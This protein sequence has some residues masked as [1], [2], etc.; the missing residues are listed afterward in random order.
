LQDFNLIESAYGGLI[1]NFLIGIFFSS[2]IAFFSL[3][4]KLHIKTNSASHYKG[5]KWFNND[6]V[7]LSAGIS[8]GI[9]SVIFADLI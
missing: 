1:S 4:S 7:N 8:G 5:F 2:A 9:V 6:A 3:K